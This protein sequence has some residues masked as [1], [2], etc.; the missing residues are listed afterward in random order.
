MEI[1]LSVKDARNIKK[2]ISDLLEVYQR[3]VGIPAD[4]IILPETNYPADSR[5]V[6]IISAIAENEQIAVYW[7]KDVPEMKRK[8]IAGLSARLE[9]PLI[10]AR[11]SLFSRFNDIKAYSLPEFSEKNE[12]AKSSS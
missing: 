4:K 1:S 10:L 3:D 2:S 6:A 9:H 7:M 8:I 11:S 12:Q 5:Y